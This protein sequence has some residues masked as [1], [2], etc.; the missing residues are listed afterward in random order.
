M[1]EC[2]LDAELRDGSARSW[3]LEIGLNENV[4]TIWARLAIS[5][6]GGQHT[7]KEICDET[8]SDLN[9]FLEILSR[10]ADELLAV[11]I[12]DPAWTV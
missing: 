7:A 5:S 10:A 12:D 2:Y 9:A 1:V 3:L 6:L 8:A 11:R 4:W